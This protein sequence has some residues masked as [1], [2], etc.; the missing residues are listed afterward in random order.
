MESPGIDLRI[1]PDHKV[2]YRPIG[3]A[4]P[5]ICQVQDLHASDLLP[6]VRGDATDGEV[7]LDW[8]K[9][10]L[11]TESYIGRI[12]CVSVPS[13]FIVVR[14]NG[15]VTVSGNT[16]R[17]GRKLAY[18]AENDQQLHE[19]C[20]PADA[21]VQTEDGFRL[22][23]DL[24]LKRYSGKIASVSPQGK[25]EYKVVVNWIYTKKKS[26]WL[27]IVVGTEPYNSTRFDLVCTDD[28]RVF[29][30]GGP[31]EAKDILV[32][33][34]VFTAG[35]YATTIPLTAKVWSVEP[36]VFAEGDPRSEDRFCLTVAD[37]HNF[38]ANGVLVLN[39]GLDT[40]QTFTI[41]P[42]L[43]D[44]AHVKEQQELIVNDHEIQE[45]CVH[46]HEVGMFVDQ[47]KRAKVEQKKTLE[48]V[49]Y[50]EQL[51]EFSGLPL[52]NPGSIHQ[53]RKHSG[54]CGHPP[55]MFIMPPN[56]LQTRYQSYVQYQPTNNGRDPGCSVLF[57]KQT[58]PSLISSSCL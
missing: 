50:K 33:D 3:S 49:K 32:G 54:V 5:R 13:G 18:D 19:Y 39:C 30:Y 57:T 48:L 52:L 21:T 58:I 11:T 12:Y 17:E 45:L 8:E 53:L 40:S 34:V 16:D 31:K 4:S 20:L 44:A 27:R 47:E 51:R 55:G 1:T 14:R 42:Q 15:K 38:F 36:V 37:N 2:L 6:S 25:I 7:I 26:N 43:W 24:V 9:V 28:H 23:G 35:T 41:M 46:M 22:I 10:T 29:T 56:N